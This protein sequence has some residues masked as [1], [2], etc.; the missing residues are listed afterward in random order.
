MCFVYVVAAI[1]LLGE[2][3]ISLRTHK[4]TH[5]MLKHALVI[6]AVLTVFVQ[7]ATAIKVRQRSY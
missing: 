3:F 4:H 1:H 6:A 7:K 2:L 5:R